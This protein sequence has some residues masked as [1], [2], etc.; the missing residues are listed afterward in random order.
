MNLIKTAFAA[1]ISALPL[2]ALSDGT[3]DGG[4]GRPWSDVSV[5]RINKEEPRAFFV[6]HFTLDGASAPV[7]TDGVENIYDIPS[8]KLLNGV[9][10]FRFLDSPDE[11]DPAFMSDSFDDSGWDGIDV[12]CSWQARGYDTVFYNN[13]TLEMF[14]DKEGRWLPGFHKRRGEEMS[15][16][17]RAPFVPEAHRQS[18]IYRRTFEVPGDWD[19]R[20]VFV[21]FCGV[22]TGFELYVNGKFAGYSE[23]SFT[24]A[25]FNITKFLRKGRNSMAVRVFKFT[26]GAYFEMQ[27]M[28]H[29]MGIIRDV[30]LLARP[31]LHIGDYYAPHEL[32]PDMKDARMQISATVRNLSGRAAR[33]AELRAWL[34]D[35]STGARSRIF[36]AAVPEAAPGGVAEVSGE[37][38]VRGVRLWSP[39]RPS[40]YTLVLE[41]ADADGKTLEAVSADYAFRKFEIRQKTLFLNG[42]RMLIKGANRHDWSPDKGKAVD[43]SWMKKDAE[44]MAAANV[45]AV[46]TAHYPNDDKFLMLCSRYGLTVMDEN[47]FETHGLREEIPTDFEWFVPAAVDRMKNMVLR[48]RNVPCVI[49]WSLGN[50]NGLFFNRSH[51]AMFDFARAADP[52]RPIHS[53]PEMRDP[54]TLKNGRL[55]SPTDFVSGM[56]G[57]IPRIRWY[58]TKMENETRPFLFCEYMHSMGN[59]TG[60]LREIWD[61]FRADPSLNGGYL[62]DW[63]DQSLYLP[64]PGRPGGKFLS[65]GLDWGTKPTSGSFCLNGIIF[66]DRECPPKYFEV[67]SVHQ[68]IRFSDVDGDP[69]RLRLKSEFFDTD[70]GEFDASL[71]VERNG[72]CVLE[73]KLDPIALA[74][75]EER[76]ISLE[77]PEVPESE[78]G[79]AEYFYTLAF[80]A[81][82][83]LPYA[84]K[85]GTVAKWQRFMGRSAPSPRP[86]PAA[87]KASFDDGRDSLRVAFSLPGGASGELLFDKKGANL[88][89]LK[90]GGRP[91]ITKPLDFDISQAWIENLKGPMRDAERYGLESLREVRGSVRFEKSPL[92]RIVCEKFWTNPDGDGFKSEISYEIHGAG[93]LVSASATKLNATPERLDLPRVGV[94]M[95]VARELGAAEYFGRG[96]HGNFNDRMTGEDVGLY[97]AGVADFFEPYPKLQ[98]SGNREETRWM[99]L[100]GPDGFGAV[101]KAADG[102]LPFA[103]LPNSQAEMK[104][105]AHPYQLSADSDS[106]LRIAWKVS[107]VGNGSHGPETFDVYRPHFKGS[108]SWRFWILPKP[109][110]AGAA[111]AAYAPLPEPGP[112][113]AAGGSNIIDPSLAEKPSGK[114][115]SNGAKTSYSSIDEKWS[116]KNDTLTTTAEGAFAFHTREEKNP[117]AVIDLGESRRIGEIEILNRA[118]H[119]AFRTSPISV[120]LSD[121]GKSWRKAWRSDVAK[122]RWL[123]KFAEPERA[124]HVKIMLEKTGY[125]HLKGV[126]VFAP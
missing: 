46:R 13:I 65:H 28:P 119:N 73:K 123:V 39:D 7:D 17:A 116:P 63:V 110:G 12:P 56:Y 87:A 76:E 11:M 8:A 69:S 94:R 24:P 85:G 68:N 22:R 47:N 115:I 27:D 89:S 107:G 35:N 57:G 81:R 40:L 9:W 1:I 54:A 112:A 72:V 45:N 52:A 62:W 92:P 26:T 93:V 96:P 117:F 37:A 98:D 95:G 21:R 14:F 77:L 25:E 30:V 78:E 10:K 55:N 16:A 91:V 121:D 18:G 113:R 29:M 109:A 6:P 99:S 66:A 90:F 5:F 111:E 97:R 20:E 80:A 104:A 126:K 82:E 122:T 49:I 124:R 86:A 60:N 83:D 74:P 31:K 48:D 120:F 88:A 41:L 64:I 36:S 103:L 4:P 58:Q 61:E 75:G 67:K 3:D 106:E 118:D 2:A 70:A 44:L 32:S 100:C 34:V 84:K 23:D 43:F 42:K 33:G 114:W 19:G 50:E 125:L 51:R 15:E 102:P 101:F 38:E 79:G 71:K 105:L 59:S 108:V 53:E